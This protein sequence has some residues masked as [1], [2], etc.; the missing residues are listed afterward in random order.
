MHKLWDAFNSHHPKKVFSSQPNQKPLKK[1]I[2]IILKRLKSYKI[3]LNKFKFKI[4]TS[5]RV[6]LPGQ[7]W[8]LGYYDILL[9]GLDFRDQ[10][11]I[12]KQPRFG[13][14]QTRPKTR[15]KHVRVHMWPKI[16][17]H[18]ELHTLC[19]IQDVLV[20]AFSFVRRKNAA[21]KCWNC[22]E[23]LSKLARIYSR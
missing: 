8:I 4:E 6:I 14:F 12:H 3:I 22:K 23:A 20:R 2:L 21:W 10:F 13:E 11:N 9:Q 5:F 15:T 16:L 1:R 7:N 18:S 17:S 19:A